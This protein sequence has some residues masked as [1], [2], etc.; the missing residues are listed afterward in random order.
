MERAPGAVDADAEHL[1]AQGGEARGERLRL[2]GAEGDGG[3]DVDRSHGHRAFRV[4]AR[5][6][7]RDMR[8]AAAERIRGVPFWQ[9]V[10][11]CGQA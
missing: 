2:R 8:L 11:A 4:K 1:V 6:F 10:I 7:L 9:V 5:G 3:E